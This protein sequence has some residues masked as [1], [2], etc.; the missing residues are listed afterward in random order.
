MN[1]QLHSR[2]NSMVIVS[3]RFGVL[4]AASGFCRAQ[5]CH[6]PSTC[7]YDFVINISNGEIPNSPTKPHAIYPY[8]GGSSATR[9][10]YSRSIRLSMRFLTMLTSGTKRDASCDRTSFIKCEWMSCLRCLGS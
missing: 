9:S 10:R 2:F 6:G 1:I 4:L 8:V 7:S 5:V 3:L